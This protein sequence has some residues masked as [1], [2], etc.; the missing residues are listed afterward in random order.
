LGGELSAVPL[1]LP[2]A[3]TTASRVLLDQGPAINAAQTALDARLTTDLG[4]LASGDAYFGV[5]GTGCNLGDVGATG[6]SEAGAPPAPFL[7]N[8]RW[9]RTFITDARYDLEIYAPAI[10][11]AMT[12]MGVSANVVTAARA[13]VT[14]AGWIEANLPATGDGA[15]TSVEIRFPSYDQSGHSVATTQG[16]DLAADVEAWLQ[17]P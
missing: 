16:A 8:L 17:P 14:R 12:A 13:G 4:S 15:E 6:P 1:L 3:R 7:Q 2:A 11:A 5:Q 9:V 10:P